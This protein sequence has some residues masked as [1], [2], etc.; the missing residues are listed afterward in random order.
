RGLPAVG[1]AAVLASLGAGAATHLAW[2][3]L[4]HERFVVHGFQLL[5]HASTVLGSAILFAWLARW[6]RRTPPR[7]LP[8]RL[9]LAPRLR[10]GLLVL[11]I[12][13]SAGWALA[14]AQ[15]LELPRTVDAWRDALRTTGMA[16]AQALALS[17]I[18]YAMLWRLLR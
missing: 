10:G 11:L 5:Q 12:V 3:A 17:T 6:W 18:G 2:D 9:R 16:A 14:G 1:W 13:A 8:A 7:E 15:S 4:T